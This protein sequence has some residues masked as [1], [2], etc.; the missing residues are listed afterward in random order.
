MSARDLRERT[1]AQVR[2]TMAVAM[3]ADPHALDRLAGNA[4]G[5]LDASTLSFVRE[6]RTL[7]LAV[8]A[9]LT[10]VLG[11]HRYGRDP[12]DRMICMACG[13]ERCHTIHAVSHVLA[14][15]AVQPG[16]V[17]RPEAWR[18]ADAYYTGVEGR[19]VV[20]AIE[21][22]DAGYI[23]RPAPHSAGADNDAGTGVVIIDRATGALT[24]WP[25]YDTPALTSYYHAYRR[26][27]L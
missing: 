20:L 14:A 19:H 23:A 26:G 11:V 22:F 12:Y 5:A 2:S 16:H 8:S 9:A 10:T 17:D 7:A 24:R 25:S 13:I 15:Y 21:E 3:R 27:E 4:A 1:V 6:A 18:R